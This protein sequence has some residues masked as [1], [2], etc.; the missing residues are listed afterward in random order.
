MGLSAASGTRCRGLYS[1]GEVLKM[2]DTATELE[3]LDMLGDAEGELPLGLRL[4]A[5]AL[6]NVLFLLVGELFDAACLRSF[7]ARRGCVGERAEGRGTML[8]RIAFIS[9]GIGTL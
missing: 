7:V 6:L 8:S 9:V 2:E 4:A 5:E 1:T 3:F